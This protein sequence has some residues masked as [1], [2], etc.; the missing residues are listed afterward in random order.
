MAQAVT[1]PRF[2]MRGVGK[3]FGATI[4]LDGADLAVHPGEV[5]A[6]VGQNGAGKSTL[7]AILAGAIAADEGAMRI[8]G[9][10]YAPREPFESRRAGVA[11][12][13]QELSLAPH[14]SVMENIVLGIEPVRHGFVQRRRMR[15][16]ALEAMH[17]LGH[18][19]IRPDAQVATLQPA[20]QQL[21][22]IARALAT[23]CRVLVLDEPTSS[24]GPADVRV[25]FDLI[26]RLKARGM[27]IVYIS[28]FI[29]EVKAV[30]DRF[31]VL[32]DGRNAGD[33]VTAAAS[34]ADIVGMM[35]GRTPDEM[36][37]RGARAAGEPMLQLDRVVPGSATLTLHRG[38]ILGIAGLLGSGRTRLLR[39]IFGLEPVTSGTIA[40]GA[41]S[42]PS[43]PH[44]RWRQGVGL[45]SE[46]RAGE[47]LALGLSI[48]DNM[49]LTR[50]EPLGTSFAVLPSRQLAAASRWIDRLGIRCAGARQT[51]GELSGGN[52]QKVAMARLLHH[53]VDVLVLDEPTRGIDVASKAQI[54]ALLDE[55]VCGAGDR[56]AVLLVSSYLPELLGVCDRIAV[57]SRGRL[58]PAR[59]VEEW[60]EHSL[61]M[62]ASGAKAA[63]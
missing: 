61:L 49:T 11:M 35:V 9:V 25:L 4:A 52:Q 2:E 13:H 32:R 22:E 45:L 33:G 57:M 21:V 59:P 55:L 19:D 24:L 5:C 38:E 63:S 44:D 20:A 41:Y 53:D 36:Y 48:A 28:H 23:G 54:Y 8:D 58:G 18:D 51:V 34:A 37:P 16:I 29:E 12:I 10:P 1:Q 26:G 56:K 7:M 62:H 17:Q 50:L 27:A 14:L 60:T 47:G 39:A 46:D 43:T 42:G 6:L 30:S 3:R 40:V 31:V 15:D